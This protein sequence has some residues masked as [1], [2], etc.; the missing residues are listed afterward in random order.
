MMREILGDIA[1]VVALAGIFYGIQFL[2]LF[3]Q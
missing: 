1:G 2:P 3:I